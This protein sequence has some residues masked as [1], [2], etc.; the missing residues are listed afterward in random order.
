MTE[1]KCGILG[2]TR[3]LLDHQ[4]TW[5]YGESEICDRC[6]KKVGR[7]RLFT[8]S[9]LRRLLDDCIV[10]DRHVAMTNV[11]CLLDRLGEREINASLINSTV[12]S[13]A[14]ENYYSIKVQVVIGLESISLSVGC[15]KMSPLYEAWS[16][17]PVGWTADS[18]IN[19]HEP[20]MGA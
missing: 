5:W 17:Y 10:D 6:M 12:V 9:Q 2:C 11:A 1:R 18:V 14:G 8:P 20:R 19:W 4:P 7:T 15:W 13:V 3:T 16:D